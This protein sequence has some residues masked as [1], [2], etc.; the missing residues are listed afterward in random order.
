[1]RPQSLPQLSFADFEFAVQGIVLSP[2]LDAISHFLRSLPEATDFVRADVEG[3]VARPRRGRPGLPLDCVL[4]SF[5][6]WRIDDLTYR[7][8]RRRIADSPPLRQFVGLRSN[9]VPQHHAFQRAF[10]RI[11][12]ATLREIN[13]LVVAR[14][15]AQGLVT[16]RRL[17]IDATVVESDILYPTD[18]GLLSDTVRVLC[19]LTGRLSK[20]A[21][22]CADDFH[23]H[24]RAAKKRAYEIH[25]LSRRRKK[26]VTGEKEKYRALLKLAKAAV[27]ESRAA[28][29][30]AAVARTSNLLDDAAIE[31]IRQEIRHFAALGDRVISQARRRIFQGEKVPAAEKI[32]SIFEPHTD[33]IVR[34]K[35]R[36]PVEFG[37]KVFL[38]ELGEGLVELYEV[39]EGSPADA[40]WLSGAL[41]EHRRIFGRA[42]EILAADRGFYTA[43]NVRILHEAEVTTEA[44]PY[45]GHSRSVERTAYQRTPEFKDAQRFR[46]GVEGRISVLA[47]GRG[48]DRCPLRG[49]EHFDLFVGAAILANN[50]KKIAAA[51]LARSDTATGP[52]A[53]A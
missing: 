7:E 43:E 48:M 49:R 44:I 53:A 22:G 40:P 36:K 23:D 13:R 8:L 12:P 11:R 15:A 3:A 14:A 19:R 2:E 41:E 16:G 25:R 17:R 34:N 46:C 47:R 20:L 39:A 9:K 51:M 29:K 45:K 5:V 38:A 31:G 10:A 4:R 42:P 35:A 50:L 30:R 1:M 52:V 26:S 27:A 28:E 33:I 37:H 6:L 21:P 32:V 24:T 18:G